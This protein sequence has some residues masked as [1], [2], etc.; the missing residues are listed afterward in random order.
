MG[1]HFLQSMAN[2]LSIC[3]KKVVRATSRLFKGCHHGDGIKHDRQRRKSRR[4]SRFFSLK[5]PITSFSTTSS[6]S[7]DHKNDLNDAAPALWVKEI[8]LGAKNDPYDSDSGSIHY[9]TDG[10]RSSCAPIKSPHNHPSMMR[11]CQTA[12][13]PYRRSSQLSSPVFSYRDNFNM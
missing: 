2:F 12:N 7:Q 9:D 5:P 11:R 3:T 4:W 10:K 6:R 13:T 8:I 1:L